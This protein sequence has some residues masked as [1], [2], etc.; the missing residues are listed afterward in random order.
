MVNANDDWDLE[1]PTEIDELRKEVKAL[2]IYVKT[3]SEME[4]NT[5]RRLS[6][7]LHALKAR[8]FDPDDA[9]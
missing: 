3:L 9:D 6:T 2:T 5:H 7:L 1:P 4:R 8:G